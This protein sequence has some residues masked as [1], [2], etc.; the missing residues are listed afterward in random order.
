MKQDRDSW[1]LSEM[2]WAPV[3]D[4]WEA[5]RMDRWTGRQRG[6]QIDAQGSRGVRWTDGRGGSVHWTDKEAEECTRQMDRETEEC[7]GQTGRLWTD[8]WGGREDGTGL[9]KAVPCCPNDPSTLNSR[10][11]R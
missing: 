3:L 5:G 7:A 8:G 10:A 1:G 9:R 4:R 6:G 11:V 2:S